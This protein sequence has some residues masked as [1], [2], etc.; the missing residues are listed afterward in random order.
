MRTIKG[1]AT[2]LAAAVCGGVVCTAVLKSL[3]YSTSWISS[4]AEAEVS[5]PPGAD[6]MRVGDLDWALSAY[7]TDASLDDFRTTFAACATLPGEGPVTCIYDRI[8]ATSTI[9]EPIREF[10]DEDYIPSRSLRRHLQKG[11]PGHCTTRSALT[12]D[13]LLAI[14]IPARVV[15]VYPPNYNG[16]NVVEV[17]IDGS[18]RLFDPSFGDWFADGDGRPLGAAALAHATAVRWRGGAKTPDITIYPGATVVL[19]EPWLYT[20]VGPRPDRWPFRAAFSRLGE[21]RPDLGTYQRWAFFSALACAAVAVVAALGLLAR[22]RVRL[23][24]GE[25][26]DDKLSLPFS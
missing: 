16:H 24:L 11:V 21:T 2:A 4:V 19:P 12:V 23:S 15:Q 17:F 6:K 10:V 7:R 20:R 1:W 26:P 5:A 8:A 13:A 25:H 14:G 18:W 9:G 3:D 22:L